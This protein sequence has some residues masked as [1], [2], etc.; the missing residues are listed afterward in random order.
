MLC[1]ILLV[2][3]TETTCSLENCDDN[4][5][6][7]GKYCYEHI[8][9][10]EHCVNQ[11][12]PGSYSCY[13]CHEDSLNEQDSGEVTL[14]D[15]QVDKAKQAVENYCEDLIKKQS[16]LLAINLINDYPEYIS[17]YSCSFYCNV[18]MKDD[19]TNLATIHVKLQEDGTFK[20]D[21]LIFNK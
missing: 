8:C 9:E 20:V 18:V 19:N 7:G 14:T 13:S 11:K 4:R 16:Y 21:G 10:T 1:A 17:E 3:Y 6:K 2:I 15:S 5:I 12:S